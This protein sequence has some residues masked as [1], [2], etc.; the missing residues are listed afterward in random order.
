M[1]HTGLR[2][3]ATSHVHTKQH[4]FM[5][6]NTIQLRAVAALGFLL[7]IAAVLYGFV[8]LFCKTA[9]AP[10]PRRPRRQRDPAAYVEEAHSGPTAPLHDDA[11]SVRSGR[12]T[13]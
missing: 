4:T 1:S 11:R 3:Q 9:F 5:Q 10:E 8:L 2:N 6:S 12:S 13:R 7:A